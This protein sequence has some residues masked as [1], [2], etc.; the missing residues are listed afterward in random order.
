MGWG[1]LYVTEGEFRV[2]SRF[3]ASITIARCVV[4]RQLMHHEA[5]N[6]WPWV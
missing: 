5:R 1:K 2:K 6:G 3:T 4:Q